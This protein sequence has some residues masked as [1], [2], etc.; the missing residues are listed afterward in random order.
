[1][2]RLKGLLLGFHFGLV[3]LYRLA[4]PSFR[5]LV[6]FSR[7]RGLVITPAYYRVSMHKAR[8]W[9]ASRLPS[10]MAGIWEKN[11][12]CHKLNFDEKFFDEKGLIIQLQTLKCD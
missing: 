5:I 2:A 11:V 10:H 9:D 8:V 12:F 4:L 1:M 3:T 7:L 6:Y